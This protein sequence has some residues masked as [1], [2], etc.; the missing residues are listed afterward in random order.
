MWKERA[1]H[2]SSNLVSPV[3]VEPIANKWCA[4]FLIDRR[5]VEGNSVTYLSLS[6]M[7]CGFLSLS[8]TYVYI[9]SSSRKHLYDIYM[10]FIWYLYIMRADACVHIY[11]TPERLTPSGEKI[12]WSCDTPL[13]LCTCN[14]K[15]RCKKLCHVVCEPT[16]CSRWDEQPTPY[17]TALTCATSFG[18][19]KQ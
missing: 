16:M 2:L 5:C 8:Y 6:I 18:L 15:Q 3:G 11:K 10:I 13:M 4:V 1:I 12:R 7:F 9:G 14:H 17:F 19:P